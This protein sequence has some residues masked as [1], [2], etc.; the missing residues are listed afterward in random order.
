MENQMQYIQLWKRVAQIAGAFAFVISVLL[1]VNYAQYKRIDPVET[2]LINSLVER[3]N[4]NPGDTLLR[5]EIRT[6]DLL[7]RKAYFTNQWQ[8]RIGGYLLLLCIAVLVIAMQIIKSNS[9][10]EVIISENEN[11][12]LEQKNARKWI[13][14]AGIILVGTALFF[15]YI[16]HNELSNKFTNTVPVAIEEVEINNEVV[17]DEEIIQAEPEQP[18][19][20][21]VVVNEPVQR[22]EKPI[23]ITEGKVKVSVPKKQISEYPS[24]KEIR[25]NHP[26]FRGPGGNGISYHINIPVSWD[27]TTGENI[28]WKLPIPLHG[29]NSPIIW[30]KKIFL[31]GATSEKRAVYC[32]DR[33]SGKILWTTE[34]KNIPGSPTSSP[35]VTDDT[36]QAAPTLA[37]DGRRVYAIFANGDIVALN[38]NG[39]QLW[40]R[41]LGAS[42]NHY[43]H[44]SSL[45]LFQNVLIIQY[46]TKTSP[47]LMGLSVSTGKTLWETPRKV[48]ISWASPIV[49][50]TGNKT[51]IFTAADPIV[52]SHDPKTGKVN[53]ELDCIFGE[54]GPSAAYS[55][56][57]VFAVNEYAKLVAIKTS[58]NPE[59][60][61]ESDEYLS[62]VP[63]PVAT[64]DLLFLATSYGVVICYNA[65]TGEQYWEHEFDN[66]F[67]SSPMLVDGKIYLMDMTGN[68]HIFKAEKEFVSLGSFSIG[69]DGM[70][71][72]AFS[73]GSIYIRGNEHLFAIGK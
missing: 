26:T 70:T 36:G 25:Q 43:G 46:D 21:E 37:T 16:T 14:I 11:S 68:M 13:S 67:Y 23:E 35:K 41:N 49:V 62:D 48:K 73:E 57:V 10:K 24:E 56:S 17:E 38:M 71:T 8:V 53:W 44:S 63:S 19:V 18:I 27:V 28:L 20:E 12:F 61:W 40:A 45:M 66:G 69:E 42:G 2:V 34:V 47:K 51:E 29:Y 7:A 15:A 6:L 58:N 50:N 33:I 30:E 3:L 55:D 60:L 22:K 39:K 32:V 54:V 65:K 1:I 64:K 72:P 9:G 52:S 31:S 5:E 4:D 59:I